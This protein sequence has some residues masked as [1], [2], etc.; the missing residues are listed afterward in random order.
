MYKLAV[1]IMI[2]T[3]RSDDD[4]NLLAEQLKNAKTDS[5]F[6]VFDRVL[7]NN[8]MLAEKIERFTKY[9]DRLTK[10]GF[11]VNAWLAPTIGYGGVCS[12]DNDAPSKYTRIVTD[13]GRT[14]AGGFCP[15]DEGFC[16]DFMNTLTALAKTGVEEIM[17]EDDY[18]LSG[19]KMFAEHG[20]CCE[21]HMKLIRERL[22]SDVTRETVNQKLYS[23]DGIEFRRGFL[24]IMGET[25]ADF[26]KKVEKTVHGVNPSIKI[27]LS[28]NAS[29]YRMEGI[30][31]GELSKLTA[32]STK[33]FIRL[34]GAPYWNQIPTY[35]ANI[36]AI[37]VQTHW[38]E[39]CGAELIC[40]GDVY[41]RPR[42]FIPS[43]YLEA[44]DMILRADGKCDGILKYM[45]D[46]ASKS[47]YEP[48]YIDRHIK[49]QP[50]YAEIDRIFSGKTAVGLNIVESRTEFENA[51][52]DD[53]VT[54]ESYHA[55]GGYQPL[56]SQWFA[57]DNS[58]P[59]TY[60]ATDCASLVF[61]E[62][63]RT[64]DENTMKNGVI[65]DAYAAKILMSRGIDVGIESL[66]R[67]FPMPVEYFRSADDYTTASV[68]S[69][70]VYYDIH[71]KNN[72]EILSEFLKI[73]GGFGNYGEHLWK[74][75]EKCPACFFY[76]NDKGCKFLVYAFTAEVSWA[77]GVWQ[78]GL[79]RSYYRQA[80]LCDG[81]EKLQGRRLPA[82]CLKS[83]ELYIL[84]KKDDKSMT[85]GLW[86]IFADSVMNPEIILDEPYAR[87]EFYNCSGTLSGGRVKLD[88]DILP[89]SFAF[90]TVFFE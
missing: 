70:A 51:T 84:C 15:L 49:N 12:C 8:Q 43:S 66:E 26:T 73:P 56:V 34:T 82:V 85:V 25:L 88:G 20:C 90:V 55:Y 89:F 52:F 10:F 50:H 77:K 42:H 9:R 18:T 32:G 58:L 19:G 68:N 53:D 60:G 64:I 54:R 35:A 63:A 1:P 39:N 48:G 33:P 17:F 4:I 74:T 44:Y 81:I 79:F 69:G 27:G 67:T 76:E 65:I 83:P 80:Q 78:K 57:V 16:N 24:K 72:A 5:I 29:S 38:L 59:I 6:L 14:L 2:S 61:G 3:D 45:T 28:A 31:M 40:E 41:P 23:P 11:K 87:A 75:A 71:V 86:N 36:E 13:K 37:R 22:G 30:D 62:N 7:D 21:R 47:S 46:Y